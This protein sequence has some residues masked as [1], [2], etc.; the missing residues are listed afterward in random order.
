MS[1]ETATRLEMRQLSERGTDRLIVGCLNEFS[2]INLTVTGRCM[3][4]ALRDGE[5]I[6]LDARRPW[7]G[8]VVLVRQA[9]GLVLHRLIW[10]PPFDFRG[11]WRTKADRSPRW[12]ACFAPAQWLATVQRSGGAAVVVSNGARAAVSLVAGLLT[13]IR[14]VFFR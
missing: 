7:I 9:G 11:A 5:R 1:C 2:R 6:G 8:D 14:G 3:M 13:R 4:P 10:G 12:D